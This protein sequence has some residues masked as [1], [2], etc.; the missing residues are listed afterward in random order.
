MHSCENGTGK[1]ASPLK[2]EDV[3]YIKK[4]WR[5]TVSPVESDL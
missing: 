2:P 5:K 1:T 4:F 3:C